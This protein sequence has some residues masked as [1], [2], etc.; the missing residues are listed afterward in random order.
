MVQY[1]QPGSSGFHPTKG[2]G[3]CCGMGDCDIL[4]DEKKKRT[5][6]QKIS[7]KVAAGCRK[8]SFERLTQEG[9]ETESPLQRNAD[10]VMTMVLASFDQHSPAPLSLHH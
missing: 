2:G 6:E 4:E 1:N 10:P 5:K 3:R 7:N 9:G 8:K